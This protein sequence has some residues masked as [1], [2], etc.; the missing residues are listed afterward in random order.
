MSFKNKANRQVCDLDIRDLKTKE[1]V[2]FFDT[3]NTNTMTITSDAVYAMAKGARKIAFQNP[4]EGTLTVEAQVYPLQ[5][6]AL[7]SD[8]II[9]TEAIVA[10]KETIK[11]GTA[12]QLTITGAESG[13][14]FVY[15]KGDF[16]GTKIAGTYASNTFTAT[17]PGDIAK[18]SYY[19]VGY[20]V[21]KTSDVNKIAFNN[22]RLPKDYFITADT[23]EKEEDGTLVPYKMTYYKA[24]I[25]RGFELSFSS[26]GDPATVSVTFDLLEDEDENFIDMVEIRP[27]S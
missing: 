9:D 4:L 5:L 12:G 26:E 8:G 17:T 18:D 13:S 16:G 23:L 7:L 27:A 25:Q 3:A 6:F 19:D 15:A 1:P 2:L 11:C 10:V 24:S 14:V 22:Q 21:K 20:L